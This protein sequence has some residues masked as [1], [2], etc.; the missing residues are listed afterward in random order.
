MVFVI[1]VSYKNKN[2]VDYRIFWVTQKQ[3]DDDFGKDV[4]R[5]EVYCKY[6]V[7]VID[8]RWTS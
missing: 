3:N 4:F 2:I 7:E 6:N 8:S 5:N 1:V